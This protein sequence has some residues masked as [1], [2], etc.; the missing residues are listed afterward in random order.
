MLYNSFEIISHSFAEESSASLGRA[1]PD[2]YAR[3]ISVS[4]V[5]NHCVIGGN[6]VYCE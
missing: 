2:L 4:T 5:T 3:L 6:S 1:L